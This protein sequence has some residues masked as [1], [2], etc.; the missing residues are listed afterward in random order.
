MLAWLAHTGIGKIS[1]G[2]YG[3]QWKESF[4]ITEDVE[5]EEIYLNEL[6]EE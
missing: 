6:Y 5:F 3:N 1:I 2:K 4:R